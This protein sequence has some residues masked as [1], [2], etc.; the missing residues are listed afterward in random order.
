MRRRTQSRS[1][2]NHH[3]GA[4]VDMTATMPEMLEYVDEL[5]ETVGGTLDFARPWPVAVMGICQYPR[6]GTAI[7]PVGRWCPK[8]MLAGEWAHAMALEIVRRA[9]ERKAW[10]DAERD[11]TKGDQ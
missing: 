2:A 8:H 5:D 4:M 7:M 6:C 1:R 3:A 11:Y 10:R 9:R